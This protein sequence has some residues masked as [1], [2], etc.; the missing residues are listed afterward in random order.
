MVENKCIACKRH[1]K[2]KALFC[3]YCGIAQVQS[4]LCKNCG[5]VLYDGAKYCS[6]CGAGVKGSSKNSAPRVFKEDKLLEYYET[7]T[8]SDTLEYYNSLQDVYYDGV[9]SELNKNYVK[10]R[11]C[12]QKAYNMHGYTGGFKLAT[13]LWNTSGSSSNK[14]QAINIYKDL[15]AKRHAKAMVMLGIIY[16]N[17]LFVVQNKERAMQW[18]EKAE[19]TNRSEL[20]TNMPNDVSMDPAVLYGIGLYSQGKREKAKDLL[21]DKILLKFTTDSYKEKIAAFLQDLIDGK[22]E[23]YSSDKDF[24]CFVKK[25]IRSSDD[26]DAEENYVFSSADKIDTEMCYNKGYNY[27]YGRGVIQNHLKSLKWFIRGGLS[28]HALCQY[29]AGYI[30][31]CG[32][33]GEPDYV[34]CKYWYTKASENG[35]SE[36][37]Q[38]LIENK[39]FFENIDCSQVV[40]PLVTE[41]EINSIDYYREAMMDVARDYGRTIMLGNNEFHFTPKIPYEK[42]TSA[43]SSYAQGINPGDVLFLYDS[44]FSHNGKKGFIFTDKEIISSLGVRVKYEKIKELMGRENSDG[45]SFDIIA[46]PSRKVFFQAY[47][48]STMK[49]LIEK[50]NE[51]VFNDGVSK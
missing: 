15:A 14:E 30:Y 7:Q 32:L 21:Q 22:R 48:K 8:D 42:I 38:Y 5:S 11:S 19:G 26:D 50:M 33:L 16:M 6:T 29:Y 1:I 35:V 43:I 3:P 28:N 25:E 51:Y 20:L 9:K 27:L 12:F 23:Y 31:A 46:L 39:G 24:A 40:E 44:T 41:E 37:T 17:G 49:L 45:A 10:A 2:E 18:F 13:L 4:D 36:A 34:K 47:E